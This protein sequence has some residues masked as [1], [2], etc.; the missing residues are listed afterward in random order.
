MRAKF[1]WM[2]IMLGVVWI[3]PLMYLIYTYPLLPNQVAVHFDMHGRVDRF[4]D[5]KELL[6]TVLVLSGLT[7]G[8]VA[9][10]RFLPSIDPK[11]KVKYSQ[12]VVNRISYALVFFLSA[13]IILVIYSSRIGRFALDTHFLYSAIGL[14][15]AY[16]GNLFNNLKP[17][18]FVGIRTPW[19]LESEEVWKKTHQ[20]GGRLW[21]V[22]GILLAILCWIFTTELAFVLFTVGVSLLVLIPVVYS[23]FCFRQL[24]KKSV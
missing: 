12:P 16:T 24:Q 3:L 8:L 18:Y 10:L 17:N 6:T 23:F 5:K 14:F 2:D 19:T 11:K 7:I 20:L 13:L 4:G 9:L 22:G 15:M 1:S 21:F